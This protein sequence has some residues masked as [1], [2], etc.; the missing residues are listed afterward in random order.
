MLATDSVIKVTMK[1]GPYSANPTSSLP[2]HFVSTLRNRLCHYTGSDNRESD[3]LQKTK[4]A[5]SHET[6]LFTICHIGLWI[7]NNKVTL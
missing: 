4:S 2:F 3:R 5:T 1:I 7:Q 6:K